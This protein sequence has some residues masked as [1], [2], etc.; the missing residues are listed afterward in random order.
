METLSLAR[1]RQGEGDG[2]KRDSK[3]R[4]TQGADVPPRIRKRRRFCKN[5]AFEIG[6]TFVAGIDD[7]GVRSSVVNAA[8]KLA[9]RMR[10]LDGLDRRRSPSYVR[11]VLTFTTSRMKLICAR[12]NKST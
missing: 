10:Q 5:N 9:S 11:T 12:R 8:G 1:R 7:E 4:V 3:K 6:H 2:A